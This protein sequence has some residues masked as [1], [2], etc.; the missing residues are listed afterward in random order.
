M[1]K[2]LKYKEVASRLVAKINKTIKGDGVNGIVYFGENNDY[3]QLLEKIISGSVTA[4]AV[5][6]RYASF[7]VGGGFNAEIN[8]IIVGR[9]SRGK[10]VKVIDLLTHAAYS[11]SRFNGFY[12]H[13]NLN[14]KGEVRNPSPRLFKNCRFAKPDDRGYTAKIG[15]HENWAADPDV[16]PKFK[17]TDIK[18][19]NIWDN[20]PKAIES[21]IKAAGGIDKYKG[22]IFFH[23]LD[24]NYIYPLSPFEQV[25]TDADSE[26][27]ISL[28]VNNEVRNGFSDKTLIQ[29]PE[30]HSPGISYDEDGNEVRGETKA[31]SVS[32]DIYNWM[33]ARGD[34]SIVVEAATN[35]AGEMEAF[36]IDTIS[37]NINFKMF[38]GI[39]KVNTNRIRKAAKAIPD[40]LIEYDSSNLGTTSGEAIIQA[41]NFYNQMTAKDRASIGNALGEV[42]SKTKIPELENNTD[43]SIKPINLYNNGNDS[44]N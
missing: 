35:D 11:C 40:I 24:N 43:W 3:P 10:E 7:L 13:A 38:E 33:G 9:D 28:Y 25:Y 2:V 32:D 12:I 36:K 42:L 1:A 15:Y 26:A 29:I 5:A 4:T 8:N 14:A 20:N 18:W 6:D 31:E 39:E 34:K 23:F 30:E 16:Y 21:Q 19:Y 41:T 22:Q 44:N 27:Q 37:S 17:K